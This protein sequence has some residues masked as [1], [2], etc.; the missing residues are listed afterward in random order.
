M[1]LI[2]EP[3]HE[4]P[5]IDLPEPRLETSNR[6][7]QLPFGSVYQGEICLLVRS[8]ER[9]RQLD[10]ALAD[11]VESK[12]FFPDV[13]VDGKQWDRAYRWLLRYLKEEARKIDEELN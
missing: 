13:P 6:T 10:G 3:R 9:L 7:L 12:L 2:D 1:R 5:E 4:T 11:C 8:M